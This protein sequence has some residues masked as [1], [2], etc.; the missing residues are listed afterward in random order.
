[1]GK[2]EEMG[3]KKIWWLCGILAIF[4]CGRY[5]AAVRNGSLRYAMICLQPY[6]LAYHECFGWEPMH[7]GARLPIILAQETKSIG[8]G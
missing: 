3:G 2:R 8:G 1:L 7:N 4:A 5:Y 6:T